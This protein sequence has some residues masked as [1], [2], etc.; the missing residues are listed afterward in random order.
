M[1]IIDSNVTNVCSA[2]TSRNKGFSKGGFCIKCHAQENGEYPRA[3]YP[4]V[5]SPLRMPQARAAYVFGKKNLLKPPLFGSDLSMYLSFAKPIGVGQF[6][7]SVIMS[8]IR[9]GSVL[10]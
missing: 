6:V 2:R 10:G 4:A 9:R 3:L 5:R 8:R 7:E 1:T